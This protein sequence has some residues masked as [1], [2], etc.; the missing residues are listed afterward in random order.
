MEEQ[1]PTHRRTR[2]LSIF[3]K[4]HRDRCSLCGKT[5]SDRDI[6]Y[7]GYVKTG[8]LKTAPAFVCDNC[9]GKLS[10]LV[11]SE[12]WQELPYE[13]P[14]PDA[15]LWRY[16]DLSKF[17]SLIDSHKLFFAPVTS[18]ERD[19]P[20]EA[21]LGTTENIDTW[22]KWNTQYFTDE[23]CVHM[24][25]GRTDEEYAQIVKQHVEKYRDLCE[26]VREHT[27][28]SC[29]HMSDY[30]SEAMWRLYSGGNNNSI[31]IQTTYQRLYDSIGRDPSVSI[32]KI[33]YKDYSHEFFGINNAIWCKRK[34][35]DYEKEVRAIVTEEKTTHGVEMPVDVNVLI[36]NL[37]V[38]PYAPEWFYNVVK[39]VVEKYS[40]DKEILRSQMKAE[41]FY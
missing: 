16:M 28:I 36:E 29:W 9:R 23:V 26:Y 33:N 38:S 14:E 10:E 34:A 40:L 30:E 39:S 25:E 8:L 41:P 35:F 12:E 18:F 5:F 22:Y 32:G 27:S 19:D 6:A 31:A 1:I 2:E 21:A 7:Y 4:E 37:Y 3:C 15:M 20:F 13:V 24:R 11:D 17:I